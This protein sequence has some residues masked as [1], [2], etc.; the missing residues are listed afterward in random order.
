MIA[1]KFRMGAAALILAASALLSRLM[2]LVR[3]K[4]ISWQFGATHEADMY[5]AAFVVPDIIN[6]LLAGA[7]VSIT[8]IPLLA[9]AFSED[10]ENA[11]KLFS[12]ILFWMCAAS[13]ALTG[14]GEIFAVQL[15]AVVAPGFSNEQ[16]LRLA[17]FMRII[18]PGQIFFLCGSC[19]TALLFL[20]RQFAVPALSP[21]IYNGCIIAFGL[22][23]PL[24]P[25]VSE[26]F[27]MK[28]YCIGVSIG[29]FLGALLLP[30]AVALRGGL[31]IGLVTTHPLM[32]KFLIIALPLMLGQ[33][34]VVLDEQFLRIFGSM[35]AEGNVS[36]LN[37]G[38]RIAQVPV[39]LMG[40]AIAV[41]S[42]PFLVRL[43]A[44]KELDK[45]NQTLN[46]AIRSALL[47]VIPCS[48]WMMGAAQPILGIIFEGG[49]FGPGQTLA[50]LPLTQIMLAATPAWILYMVLA[51]AFYAWEDTIT[52]AL[53][54]TIITIVA[55]PC[56]YWPGVANGAWAIAGISSLSL[57]IYVG[58]LAIIWIRR[59]GNAAF[60]SLGSACT[61]MLACSLVPGAAAWLLYEQISPE[62]SAYGP[63][64]SYCVQLAT[65]TAIFGVLF[66][67]L[68]WLL[69]P[70][71]LKILWHRLNRTKVS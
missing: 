43:L 14:A 3:D 62:F 34:V 58:W 5:F 18:L 16:I 68:V 49:K 60:T 12:C 38:R 10:E 23:L 33:T 27:G 67:P 20:R 40:Q 63:F 36:L 59:H 19:F 21:L 15:A 64:F 65:N 66:L 47:L 4:I 45:F 24:F 31:K 32:G 46:T 61:R 71:F 8:I 30:Y 41:A 52:P 44:E 17:A 13:V 7:F 26:D 48:I 42:Y 53:T 70:E 55:I 2:G 25:G 69:M 51:R 29:A 22:A 11:W 6:Y 37:Y 1:A 28:G 35:L 50:C 9:R 39:S 57:F 56:Y 54:G